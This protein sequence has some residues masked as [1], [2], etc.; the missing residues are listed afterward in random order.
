MFA[1]RLTISR[2]YPDAASVSI[3]RDY[4]SRILYLLD[5][6]EGRI[7]M[8]GSFSHRDSLRSRLVEAVAWCAPRAS[9]L[10]PAGC[11]RT[12]ALRPPA[13]MQP[14]TLWSPEW[15][16]RDQPE[17]S[18]E[19]RAGMV[20]ALAAERGRLLRDRGEAPADIRHGLAGGRLLLSAGLTEGVWDAAP[21]QHS[22]GFFDAD[23]LP[24]WDTW[25][26]YA[27]LEEHIGPRGK[28]VRTWYVVSWVP[29]VLLDLAEAGMAVNPVE[30]IRWAEGDELAIER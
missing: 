23:D 19:E 12:E 13:S 10:D 1:I 15:S 6:R 3:T 21:K 30:C 26:L 7:G 29:P 17:P 5:A 28:R 27:A 20:D 4:R 22:G 2:F 25:L 14:A 16:T 9:A 11:L 18:E 8:S 24:P